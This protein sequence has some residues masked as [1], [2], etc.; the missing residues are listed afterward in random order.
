MD[1]RRRVCVLCKHE[2]DY[3]EL[4]KHFEHF[5]GNATEDWPGYRPC[6]EY[7]HKL[8]KIVKCGGMLGD[9]ESDYNERG[10]VME[11]C[12][13]CSKSLTK[14]EFY[15]E[16]GEPMCGECYEQMMVEGPVDAVITNKVM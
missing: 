13:I 3:T 16:C 11:E 4:C 7:C 1:E 2:F 14:E 8:E 15:N 12:V 10:D 5:R 6:Q 9:C